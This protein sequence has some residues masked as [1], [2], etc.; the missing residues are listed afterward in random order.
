MFQV[1]IQAALRNLKS[2]LKLR[3]PNANA[4]AKPEA[5]DSEDKKDLTSFILKIFLAA[6]II[7]LVFFTNITR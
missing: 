6:S 4:Y 7:L 3:P 5:K 1:V 2:K